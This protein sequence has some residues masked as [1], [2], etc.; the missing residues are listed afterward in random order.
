MSDSIFLGRPQQGS[1][2]R[3]WFFRRDDAGLLFLKAADGG[4][5]STRSQLLPPYGFAWKHMC[6]GVRDAKHLE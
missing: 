3:Y 1:V 4:G 5:A 2:R 6:G